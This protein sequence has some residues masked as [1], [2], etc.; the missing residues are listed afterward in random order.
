MERTPLEII[1]N[2]IVDDRIIFANSIIYN[3]IIYYFIMLWDHKG[4][5][6]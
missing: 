3:L 6:F 2:V 1:G 4:P 5:L